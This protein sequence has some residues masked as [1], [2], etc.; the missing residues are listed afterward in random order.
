MQWHCDAVG[1][2]HRI[3][4]GARSQSRHPTESA[5]LQLRVE[6]GE[7]DRDIPANALGM[8]ARGNG[9]KNATLTYACCRE[10]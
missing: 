9:L 8:M 10:L 1:D 3:E 6:D 2:L 4:A 7:M 5:A